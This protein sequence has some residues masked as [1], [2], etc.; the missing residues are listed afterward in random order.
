MPLT[1]TGNPRTERHIAAPCHDR[2]GRV[3]TSSFRHSTADTYIYCMLLVSRVVVCCLL[4]RSKDLGAVDQA[5]H[6]V[7]MSAL[8]VFV[9]A[10]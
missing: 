9:M 3:S 4:G 2:Q 6:A 5:D 1:I 8:A 7:S 10:D